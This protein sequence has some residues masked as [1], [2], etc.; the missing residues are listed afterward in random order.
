MQLEMAEACLSAAPH[1]L[2]GIPIS[3]PFWR[4]CQAKFKLFGGDSNTLEGGCKGGRGSFF[5]APTKGHHLCCNL[6]SAAVPMLSSGH[7]ECPP[8]IL[9]PASQGVGLM[10][11]RAT[12]VSALVVRWPEVTGTSAPSP[13]P[14]L[15]QE[16]LLTPQDL[17]IL[18]IAVKIHRLK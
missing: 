10:S 7:P 4:S 11:H 14:N 3:R 2:L 1:A 15:P 16:A 12:E 18:M 13:N 9:E 5:Q 8:P 6:V 17:V